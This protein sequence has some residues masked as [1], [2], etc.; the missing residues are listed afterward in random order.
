[1]WIVGID[2]AWGEKKADGVCVLKVRGKKACLETMAY[3]QG[4]DALLKVIDPFA[5]SP[6]PVIVALDAPV[7]CINEGGSRPVDREMHRLFGKQHAGCH[8]VNKRL[9]PRALRVAARIQQCYPQS[10]GKRPPGGKAGE[11][12]GVPWLMEV[13]PHAALVSLLS[14]ER[15]IKYKRG[16]VAERKV[17]FRRLQSLL[18]E[19]GR[20]LFP[21]LEASGIL[22]RLLER[23]WSKEVEDRTDAFICS[24]IGLWHWNHRGRKSRVVGDLETGFILVPVLER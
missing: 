1:M 10:S 2:L 11:V 7:V 6:E 8:P 14:L 23:T 22:D 19:Q 16:S 24:L 17:E 15:I 9:C 4:D 5:G 12:Y 20:C 13:Y 18:R 3:P 21:G